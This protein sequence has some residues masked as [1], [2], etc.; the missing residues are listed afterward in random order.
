MDE[1]HQGGQPRGSENRRLGTELG[2]A[3][4][5]RAQVQRT[6]AAVREMVAELTHRRGEEGM[7]RTSVPPVW[8]PADGCHR[9]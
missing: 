3:P 9:S 4:C 7:L 1:V 5:G 2:G 6:E 8:E